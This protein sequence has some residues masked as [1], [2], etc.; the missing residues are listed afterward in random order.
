VELNDEK[1]QRDCDDDD[2]A[3][4]LS[5]DVQ[6]YIKLSRADLAQKL[7]IPLDQIKLESITESATRNGT[8]VVVLTAEGHTY[9]YHGSNQHVTLVSS[10]YP[11]KV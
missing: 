1:P 4:S 11:Y 6:A 7:G 2:S 9:E 10:S 5:E 8:S 3:A